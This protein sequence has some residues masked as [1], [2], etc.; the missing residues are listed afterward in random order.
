MIA[1]LV[2]ECDTAADVGTDHGYLAA[3]LLQN[4]IA[5]HV[6]ATDIHAGPLARAKQ[7]A[8]EQDL[9]SRMEFHLCDGLQFSGAERAEAVILAGMGGETM[10]SILEAA[11]WVQ[12]NTALILQPQS[13][14]S[15]LYT[16]LRTHGIPI[17]QAKLCIDAG[18]RYVAF[19]AG[20]AGDLNVTVEDLLCQAHDPIFQDYLTVE[21]QRIT[22]ALSGMDHASR[23]MEQEK[24]ALIL[25]REYLIK[26][27]KAVEA[28]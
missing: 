3:W 20:G 24:E 21:M 6:F 2:P 19:R 8:Q 22:R 7:T 13:K 23:N 25:E 14:Q 28:W 5:Q 15:L 27:Q 17:T 10:V 18:K 16:W 26:Y 12:H 4:E 9:T 1:S 11:P